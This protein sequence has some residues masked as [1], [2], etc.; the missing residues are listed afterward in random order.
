VPRRNVHGVEPGHVHR[1]RSMPRRGNMR[2]DERRLLQSRGCR[3]H[4]LQR[5]QCLHANRHLPRGNLH[6]VEP[7]SMRGE[8]PMPCGRHVRSIEWDVFQSLCAQWHLVQRRQC[9]HANRHVPR[10]RMF[11]RESR[12]LYGERSM[13]RGR[14]LQPEL[15]HLLESS[16]AQRH[17]VQ[18][19]QRLHANRHVPKWGVRGHESRRLH[20]ERSM[21]RRGDL[22]HEHRHLFESSGDQ[23]HGM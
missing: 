8:R 3:R 15:R 16:G 21:P 7:G 10:R 2:S 18:R 5:R 19:R 22:R 9:V 6:W 11:G 13:P 23:R 20:R 4:K 1:E 12:R 14:D 17:G